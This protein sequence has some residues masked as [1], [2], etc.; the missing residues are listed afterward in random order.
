MDIRKF[1]MAAIVAIGLYAAPVVASTV[2]TVGSA[3]SYI[4]PLGL[5]IDLGLSL[6]PGLTAAQVRY[7]YN[8]IAFGMVIWIAFAAD[9]RKSTEFCIIATAMAA[10][11]AWAGWFTTPNPTGQWGL[12]ILCAILSIAMYFTEKKRVTFGVG[13]GGDPMLN[14][15]LFLLIFQASVGLVNGAGIYS[16]GTGAPQE[17]VCGN[18]QYSACAINGNVQ[19]MSAGEN[20]GTNGLQSGATDIITTIATAGWGLL[21][22]IIQ[23]AISIFVFSYVVITVY[24]WIS[25]SAPALLF[26]GILQLGIWFVYS[27]TIFRWIWKPMPGDARV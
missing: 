10:F 4:G 7:Y 5:Q 21:M 9:E 24:P 23:L 2:T 3:A 17:S 15:L 8:V 6:I 25:S 13:G 27:M 11:T 26:L 12:I 1:L 19:L 22:M 18:G 20:T 16:A 14:I